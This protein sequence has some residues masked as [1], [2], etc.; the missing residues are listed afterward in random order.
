MPQSRRSKGRAWS[1]E[2][3]GERQA[4]GVAFGPFVDRRVITRVVTFGMT[5]TKLRKVGNSHGVII[6]A[7]VLSAAGFKPDDE[8]DI[9]TTDGALVINR[10]T[11]D[12]QD[13]MAAHQETVAEYRDALRELGR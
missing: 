2:T 9:Y 10:V 1:R 12:Y 13:A 3:P 4:R 8:L 5:T 7:D 11:Q 6:P